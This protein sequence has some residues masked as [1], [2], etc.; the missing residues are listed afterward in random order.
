[1]FI[2][3]GIN[4]TQLSFDS[5]TDLKCIRIDN[6]D[7]IHCIGS[8]YTESVGFKSVYA[9]YDGA[10]WLTDYETFSKIGLFCIEQSPNNDIWLGTGDGIYINE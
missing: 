7:K 8:Y 9:V 6:E 1:V 2:F 10:K 3:D 4:A 5:N